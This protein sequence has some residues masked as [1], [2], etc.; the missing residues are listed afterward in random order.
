MFTKKG[1]PLRCST[2]I[3]VITSSL[4]FD[5]RFR[6]QKKIV[7]YELKSLSVIN[8][9]VIKDLQFKFITLFRLFSRRQ[10]LLKNILKLMNG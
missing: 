10:S 4:G 1:C 8:D 5:I 9:A 6:S 7:V 3:P 2:V